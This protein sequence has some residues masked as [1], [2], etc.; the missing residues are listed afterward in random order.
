MI[1]LRHLDETNQDEVMV[2][3]VEVATVH[4][5]FNLVIFL[6]IKHG[7]KPKTSTVIGVKNES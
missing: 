5:A 3:I 4:K 2:I 6:P 1:G 7:C